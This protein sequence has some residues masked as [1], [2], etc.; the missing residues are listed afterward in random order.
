MIDIKNI[1]KEGPYLILQKKYLEALDAGQENIEAISIS[2]Y[3][4]DKDEVDSRFVNLKIIKNEDFIFFTNYNSPKSLAFKNKNQVS[5][6]IFW[7]SINLQI[8]IKAF[9]KK[10]ST[11]FNNEYFK[12]RSLNKN[13]LAISSSQS[14]PI[15]SYDGVISNFE[16]VK[17]SHDLTKCPP[18]WGGFSF[19]PYE[20]EFWEGKKYRL[21]KRDLYVMKNDTWNHSILQP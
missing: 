13:A 9:I 5:V 7:P 10:T 16:K 14:K 3:N 11:S 18:Y 4:S 21:N 8:R 6:L 15:S 12:S 20:V 17:K 2:T 19:R 1:N